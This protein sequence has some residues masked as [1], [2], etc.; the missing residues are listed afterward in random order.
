MIRAIGSEIFLPHRPV[1]QQGNDLI[2]IE[3]H[4][5]TSRLTG[6]LASAPLAAWAGVVGEPA[7]D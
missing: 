6:P 2:L 1:D 3:P 5:V 4:G 7:C